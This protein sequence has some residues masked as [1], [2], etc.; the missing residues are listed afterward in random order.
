MDFRIFTTGGSI[1]KI[2]STSASD[3]VV[4]DPQVEAIL[5]EANTSFTYEVESLS[6]KDSLE[7]TDE[8]RQLISSKVRSAAESRILITHGT[9]TMIATALALLDIPGKV[10]VLTGAMQPAAF[11]QSDAA[12]NVGCAL[13]ALQTL[14][15]GVYLV[16]NGRLFD[17]RHAR[18]NSNLDRFE[19]TNESPEAVNPSP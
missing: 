10:I 8:D 14:P 2:Y 11:K 17:P 7:L 6:N 16:M 4:G 3:F 18:K 15:H 1:D 9:D 13:I 5:H 19:T 12:F